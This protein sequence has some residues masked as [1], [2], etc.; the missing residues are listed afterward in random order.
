MTKEGDK[1]QPAS[2]DLTS[3][4]SLQL[5]NTERQHFHNVFQDNFQGLVFVSWQL[6]F[7]WHYKKSQVTIKSHHCILPVKTIP[8]EFESWWKGSM[9]S[10][11]KKKKKTTSQC[12]FTLLFRSALLYQQEIF[13]LLISLSSHSRMWHKVWQVIRPASKHI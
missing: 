10:F 12:I 8:N 13:N 4:E 1:S 5:M 3:I 9:P 11:Q 6:L 2:M 7:T